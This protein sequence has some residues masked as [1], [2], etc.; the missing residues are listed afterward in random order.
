MVNQ[1][2]RIKKMYKKIAFAIALISIMFASTFVALPVTAMSWNG[3]T[4]ERQVVVPGILYDEMFP[5]YNYTYWQKNSLTVGFTAYGETVTDKDPLHTGSWYGV[6]L[7]YPSVPVADD[8]SGA[9]YVIEHIAT[10]TISGGPSPGGLIY[11][12]D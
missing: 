7:T 4:G 3:A 5:E 2:W 11:A 6:G 8:D 10:P 1:I 12:P 9:A